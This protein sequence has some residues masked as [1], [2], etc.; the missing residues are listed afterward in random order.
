MGAAILDRVQLAVAVVD[1]DAQLPCSTSFIVPGGSS[2]ERPDNAGQSMSS[3]CHSSGSGVPFDRLSA[4]LTT[5]SPRI[6]HF[7]RTG[8][9]RDPDLAPGAPPWAAR[10]PRLAVLPLTRS[11]SIEVAACEIAQPAALE[12]DRL[13]RLPVVGEPDRDGDLVAAERILPLRLRVGVSS[14]P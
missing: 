7:S 3:P 8:R 9:Q 2:V 5:P 13:D 10:R 4:T 12:A 14:S 6:A 11:V 1:A